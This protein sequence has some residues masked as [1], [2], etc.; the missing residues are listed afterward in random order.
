M[1]RFKNVKIKNDEPNAE[2]V[3]LRQS[4]KNCLVAHAAPN[5]NQCK[6][7]PFADLE[8]SELDYRLVH[9]QALLMFNTL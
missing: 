5:A 7:V 8:P 4:R 2:Q 1:A 9:R 3:D 6:D